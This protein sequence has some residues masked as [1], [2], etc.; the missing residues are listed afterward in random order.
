VIR[1][2]LRLGAFSKVSH[3]LRENTEVGRKNAATVAQAIAM[4]LL[5]GVLPHC[6]RRRQEGLLIAAL[7]IEDGRTTTA[8]SR[9][10]WPGGFRSSVWNLSAFESKEDQLPFTAD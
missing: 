5:V 7:R 6:G 2:Y 8:K 1:F 10:A 9:Q 4:R 3:V